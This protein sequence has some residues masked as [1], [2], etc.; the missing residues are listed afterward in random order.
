MQIS[1]I[2]QICFVGAGTMGCFNSLLA[3]S[4]GYQAVVFDVSKTARD[5]LPR[6]L[7][8]M[9]GALADHGLLKHEAIPQILTCIR[10]SDDLKAATAHADLVSESVSEKLD[11]KRT[12]HEQLDKLCDPSVLI[13]TNT[14]GLLVSQLEDVFTKSDRFAALHSHLGSRLFDI[15]G[16]THMTAKSL[17]I[18]E[19]Y[20]R[21]LNCVPL[22]LRKENPG[23]VINA[24]LGPLLTVSQMMVIDHIAS[25]EDVDRAWMKHEQAVIGPFG[26]MD[27]FGLNVLCDSWQ[28]PR[29]N[30]G[31]LQEKV[32]A[33]LTPYVAA[34]HLGTKTGKGFYDYPDPNYTH[35]DFLSENT[36]LSLIHQILSTVLIVNA[37]C[38]AAADVADPEE[39]DR[40]WMLSF[41]LP[42]G[43]FGALDDIGTAEF[44]ES[45]RQYVAAN[46]LPIHQ[47]EIVSEYLQ[48]L[49]SQGR[50]GR[51]LG[52]GVYRYPAPAYEADNFI[53]SD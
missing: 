5:R 29:P 8:D 40:A 22:L 25:Q 32:L 31:H 48:S 19:R 2:H 24:M 18:L 17:D 35:T 46:V 21:S 33:L 37:I 6:A 38:I 28:H 47:A 30:T 53:M 52:R 44:L 13:T 26:L 16:S 41:S 51:A 50:F 12:V 10:I 34:G 4:A 20:V 42:R 45:Y 11:I 1:E 43:P 27:L 15:V 7:R 39:I 14:S 23:Y 49:V 36:D 3:A 9:A